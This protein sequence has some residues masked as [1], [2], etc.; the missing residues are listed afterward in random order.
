MSFVDDEESAEW[1]VSVT[2]KAREHTKQEMNGTT[3]YFDYADAELSIVKTAT[4]KHVCQKRVSE[5]GGHFRGYDEAAQEAYK[6]Y[7]KNQCFRQGADRAIRLTPK[8]SRYVTL[9]QIWCYVFSS[10]FQYIPFKER[11][12]TCPL[13]LFF[14]STKYLAN[15][16]APT[17][18][19]PPA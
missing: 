13:S 6:Y 5:K 11:S 16:P 8:H 9:T 15:I 18:L 3:T 7:S 1:V 14:D 17:L 12:Y 4:G 2:A 10:I 19:T